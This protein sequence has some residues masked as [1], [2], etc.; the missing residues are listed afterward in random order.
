MAIHTRFLS[1]RDDDEQDCRR[2][3]LQ[4]L[5]KIKMLEEELKL[6]REGRLNQQQKKKCHICDNEIS[7]EGSSSGCKFCND[8]RRRNQEQHRPIQTPFHSSH[9]L[10]LCTDKFQTFICNSCHK[11]HENIDM[12]FTCEQCDFF[13]DVKCMVMP[14]PTWYD[15]FESVGGKFIQHSTHQHRMPLIK[16]GAINDDVSCFVCRLKCSGEVCYGCKRCEYFLH[17]SCAQLPPQI[18][19]SSFHNKHLLFFHTSNR[20]FRS[21]KSCNKENLIFTYEC[22]QCDCILCGDCASTIPHGVK[23]DYHEHPLYLQSTDDDDNL[24]KCDGYDSYCKRP[25]L[26]NSEEINGTKSYI[27]WCAKCDFKVHMLCGLLPKIIK[28]DYHI[29]SLVLFDLALENEFGEYGCDICE[30]KRDPRFCA[31]VCEECKFIAHVHC[32]TSQIMKVLKG[33][34]KNLELHNVGEMKLS[35]EV[36]NVWVVEKE[37]GRSVTTLM[38]LLNQISEVESEKLMAYFHFDVVNKGSDHDKTTQHQ[39]QHNNNDEVLQFSNFIES[40]QFISV[41]F[42]EFHS[43]FQ[44]RK[45]E[46][47]YTDLSLRVVPFKGYAIPLNLGSVL[48]NLLEKYGDIGESSTFSPAMKSIGIFFTC[49]VLKQMQLTLIADINKDHL[50]HWYF[51]I[52]FAK[53]IMGFE[54]EFLEV[55]LKK[56]TQVFFYRQVSKLLD[57]DI[58]SLRQSKMDELENEKD[59]CKVKFDKLREFQE[60][61]FSNQFIKKRLNE[62]L[63]LMW[64]TVGEVGFKSHN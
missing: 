4:L 24:M 18:Y 30:G 32:L 54:V 49:K 10:K 33:D 42:D 55:S 34:L 50:R 37:Q 28:Y 23:F 40:H 15:E 52:I 62:G 11:L 64:K 8:L 39:L 3:L 13:M 31:Y 9:P 46:I 35:N 6:E 61:S 29:H 5:E 41:L 48:K 51:Y 16:D 56:I 21:C 12:Y 27:F 44:K 1:R 36:N 20:A 7:D 45:L 25:T 47:K 43:N 63:K 53:E 38:D 59:K 14:Q 22:R 17:E 58:K 60:S 26:N 2:T 19:G 57:M